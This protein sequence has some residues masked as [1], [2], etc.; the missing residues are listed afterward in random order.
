MESL[1]H[2][3]Q[4]NQSSQNPGSQA[5]YHSGHKSNPNPG[6]PEKEMKNSKKFWENFKR[7][8]WFKKRLEALTGKDLLALR[9]TPPCYWHI[10]WGQ[11]LCLVHSG[12]GS[13]KI[14]CICSF[15]NPSLRNIWLYPL[16]ALARQQPFDSTQYDMIWSCISPPSLTV[17]NYLSAMILLIPPS[18]QRHLQGI[19]RSL[20]VHFCLCVRSIPACICKCV[21][22]GL[23]WAFSL[24][25]DK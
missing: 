16:N 13:W 25:L 23:L 2:P 22:T 12:D 15:I 11:N 1:E 4:T 7:K 20:C 21:W 9:G 14:I 6:K 5:S 19:G 24:A 18:G 10:T 17:C 3:S 8:F